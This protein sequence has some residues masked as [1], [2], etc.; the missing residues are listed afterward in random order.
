M[1]YYEKLDEYQL[2]REDVLER[3]MA[4]LEAVTADGSNKRRAGLKKPW[5]EDLSHFD[6]ASGHIERWL[7]GETVDAD[8]G[9]HPLVHAGWRLIAIACSETGNHPKYDPL[10]Y[11]GPRL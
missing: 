7:D 6:R 1:D 2:E 8:S 4:E 10:K 11:D 5:W 3:F 9:R